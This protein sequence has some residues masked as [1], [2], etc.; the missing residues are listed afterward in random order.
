V[1]SD[2]LKAAVFLFYSLLDEQQRRLFAGLQ[3]TKLGHGGDRHSG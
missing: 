2:E 3:S 1:S